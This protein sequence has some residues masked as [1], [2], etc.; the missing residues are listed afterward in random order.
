MQY[1]LPEHSAEQCTVLA[2]SESVVSIDSNMRRQMMMQLKEED[3]YKQIIQRLECGI[4][5]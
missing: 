1:V 2:V 4:C 5:F 3:Q